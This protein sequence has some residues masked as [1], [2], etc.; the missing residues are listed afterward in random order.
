[1]RLYFFASAL[2]SIRS[3][4]IAD[5]K[6]REKKTNSKRF[7]CSALRETYQGRGAAGYDDFDGQPT[8]DSTS[9][10]DIFIISFVDFS[11]GSAGDTVYITSKPNSQ[12]PAAV[13]V[14]RGPMTLE[15]LRRRYLGGKN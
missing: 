2:G 13:T 11:K 5:P 9:A 8:D 1:V 10:G 4:R 6:S 12:P 3:G 15:V 7:G 14:R